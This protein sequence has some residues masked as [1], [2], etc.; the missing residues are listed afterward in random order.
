MSGSPLHEKEFFRIQKSEDQHWIAGLGLALLLHGVLAAL[1]LFAS[2]LLEAHLP[3]EEAVVVSLA[4]PSP[5]I[6]RTL[7]ERS[8]APSPS[9]REV[10]E[11]KPGPPK[12]EL[13]QSTTP[14]PAAGPTPP[15][16]SEK[17]APEAEK[18][19]PASPPQTA[20]PEP[21]SQPEPES[22]PESLTTE[23]KEAVEKA[24]ISLA[25][26]QRKQRLA[27][28]TRLQAERLRQ[29]Q[30][31]EKRL[32]REI[33]RR[34]KLAEQRKKQEEE[35]R[36]R[37]EAEQRLAE[38]VE[39]KRRQEEEERIR[40]EAEQ[41]LAEQ[42]K[43]QRRLEELR[44][45]Q[46]QE[47]LEEQKRQEEAEALKRQVAEADRRA[48]EAVQRAEAEAR[49]AREQQ[50]STQDP[51]RRQ[52]GTVQGDTPQ[53]A[54]GQQE[55][56]TVL[57]Q[58]YGEQVATRLRN[59]WKLP[60]GRSWDTTVL[61]DVRLT[62]NSDGTVARITFNR[63]SSDPMF[64]QLVET[65]IRQASPMPRFPAVMQQNSVQLGFYFNPGGVGKQ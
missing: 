54:T 9:T 35:E 56:N 43:E 18:P 49:R 34:Q 17:P 8:S 10:V 55:G 22:K 11:Q 40:K 20:K 62:I 2:P 44:R 15:A 19:P 27:R 63:H 23:S 21:A 48:E 57:V 12:P 59:Y 53:T 51:V 61:A 29:Q 14:P 3:V 28:D 50:A 5:D 47:R 38:Q 60:E 45:L 46:E 33:E 1:F 36:I 24:P 39:A 16:A 42:V 37:K 64:D 7:G 32:A 4:P 25:P 30:E 31:A 6:M 41:R 58:M 65:T 52:T 13:D 26:V